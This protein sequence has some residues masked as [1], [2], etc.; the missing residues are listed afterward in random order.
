MNSG[1]PILRVGVKTPSE[2]KIIA[3]PND[4]DS[5]KVYAPQVMSNDVAKKVARAVS[6]TPRFSEKNRNHLIQ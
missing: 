2:K 5:V 6:D 1:G 3:D 4:H